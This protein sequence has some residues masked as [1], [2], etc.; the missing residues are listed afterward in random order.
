MV[1]SERHTSRDA[2]TGATTPAITT[3]T[4]IITMTTTMTISRALRS[5]RQRRPSRRFRHRRVVLFRRRPSLQVQN[6]IRRR[7]S[8]RGRRPTR[9]R[10]RR[11][12][13]VLPLPCR[14][15]CLQGQSRS[16]SARNAAR[17]CGTAEEAEAGETDAGFPLRV[18]VA[19]Q[20]LIRIPFDSSYPRSTTCYVL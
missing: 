19:Q 16:G 15:S 7:P 8:H 11:R 9:R 5:R 2:A 13:A 12:R 18:A 4:T 20:E 6:R 3:T 1:T 10:F 17:T 14:P